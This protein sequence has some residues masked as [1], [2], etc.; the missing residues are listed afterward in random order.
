MQRKPNLTTPMENQLLEGQQRLAGLS[1]SHTDFY[2]IASLNYLSDSF[3]MTLTEAPAVTSR[4]YSDNGEFLTIGV[5]NTD[6]SFFPSSAR[7]LVLGLLP[8]LSGFVAAKFA[9]EDEDLSPPQLGNL[10]RSN[11]LQYLSASPATLSI[12]FN[13]HLN[14]SGVDVIVAFAFLHQPKLSMTI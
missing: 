6:M 12:C 3:F 9:R 14:E 4:V 2:G 7:E 8:E 5:I 1:Q 13:L 10:R 11:M